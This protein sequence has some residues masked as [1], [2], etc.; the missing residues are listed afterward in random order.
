M[1]GKL[2]RTGVICP[3]CYSLFQA[4][5]GAHL[6][7]SRLTLFMPVTTASSDRVHVSERREAEI[8]GTT[9]ITVIVHV[10][11]PEYCRSP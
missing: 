6:G 5:F 9:T 2:R 4:S 7:L 3:G 1:F 10:R 11:V 8:V